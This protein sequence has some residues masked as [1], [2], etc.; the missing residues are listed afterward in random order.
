MKHIQYFTQGEYRIRILNI[1]NGFVVFQKYDG[2]GKL[3]GGVEWFSF[4][5]FLSDI[6]EGK[7]VATSMSYDDKDP[8]ELGSTMK[9]SLMKRIFQMQNF[10]SMKM[11]IQ[12]I[13]KGIKEWLDQ[14]TRLDGA[15]FALKLSKFIPID[16]VR[17]EVYSA[18]TQGSKE[19]LEKILKVL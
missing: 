5:D 7:Y 17:A 4:P 10:M 13:G 2:K 15:K 14:G 8:V 9:G 6:Q 3:I 18:I 11:G 16:S 12:T 19:I 1:E